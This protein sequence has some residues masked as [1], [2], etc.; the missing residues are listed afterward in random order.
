MTPLLWVG[1]VCLAGSLALLGLVLLGPRRTRVPLTRLDPGAA[2]APSR[3][4][5]ATEDAAALADRVLRRLNRT[6]HLQAALERAGMKVRP[7]ELLVGTAASALGA[8]AVG[9]LLGGVPLG[10]LLAAAA[11]AGAVALVGSRRHKRQKAFTDQ[12][13]DSLQLM[14]SS[15]RAGHSVLRALDAVSRDTE[16]PTSVEFARVVNETRVGRDMHAALEEVAERTGSEDFA[17]VVQAIAIHREVGGNL[18]EVLDGV[19]ATIRDRNQLR[20]QVASLSAEGRVSGVVLLIMPVV[21]TGL[22]FVIA[23]GLMS[24]LTGTGTGLVL[25]TIAGSLMVV[26]ALWLRKI[27]K[28]SY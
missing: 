8:G 18:A 6:D 9:L 23:P 12:L 2:P 13:D 1:V 22:L 3:L 19:G 7:A 17:W 11:P 5:S 15:L 4:A 26:G 24:R 27:V 16:A 25:L 20:R 28:V 14:A 21:V 10:L